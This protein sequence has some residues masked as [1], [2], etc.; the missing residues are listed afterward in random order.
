MNTFLSETDARLKL[1]YGQLAWQHFSAEGVTLQF[2]FEKLVQAEWLGLNVP[3]EYGGSAGTFLQLALLVEEIANF[4]PSFATALVS[5]AVLTELLIRYGSDSQKSRYLPLLSRGEIIGTLAY[6]E[7]EKELLPETVHTEAKKSNDEFVLKGEKRL[8][9]NGQSA[10]LLLV[11]AATGEDKS[12][13]LVD[14]ARTKNIVRSEEVAQLGLKAAGLSKIQFSGSELQ[15]QDRLGADANAG[16]DQF[17]YAMSLTGNLFAAAAVGI[18]NGS[19]QQSS[20]FAKSAERDGQALAQSQAIQWKIADLGTEGTAA[21][22]MTYRAAWSKDSSPEEFRL[23]A[24]M[25]KSYAASLARFHS[26]EALQ[27]VGPLAGSTSLSIEEFY[28]DAKMLE[29]IGG[30]NERQKVLIGNELG[31]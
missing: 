5:H 14:A 13:W 21:R 4:N 24:A 28:K 11:L 20:D 25:S 22:L 8:V 7:D 2:F 6:F 29:L 15:E 30:T 9:V 19:L 18:L 10:S 17:E 26:S 16:A 23:N 27:V 1:E 31:I 3:K 12:F